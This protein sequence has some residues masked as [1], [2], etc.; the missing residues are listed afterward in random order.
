[1]TKDPPVTALSSS[2]NAPHWL[3]EL[4]L[5]VRAVDPH[6]AT[7]TQALLD[8]K[9]KP[10]GS[11]GRLERLACR[12]GTITRTPC[13][14]RRTKAIVVMGADHGVA[15]EGVSAYPPEVTAQMLA[16]F[17]QGGAAINVLARQANA[18]VVVVDMGARV[19][20]K[21][22]AVLDRRI[23]AGTRS[24]SHGPAMQVTEALQAIQVGAALVETLCH[25][26]IDLVGL[27]E[28]GIGN[29]T[30]AAAL[31]AAL[32]GLP[33]A[34]VTGRGT[35]IDDAMWARKVNVI[36]SALQTNREALVDP[37]HTLA[38][39]G[40][41]EIAGLVGVCLGAAAAGVPVVLDG[42]ITT[43]AALVAV[44]LCPWAEGY[45]LASHLS[46]ERGH[47]ALLEALRLEPLFDLELRLGEGTG[48][49]LA[50]PFIDAALAILHDMATFESAG[51]SGPA[52]DI[53]EP[54]TAPLGAPGGSAKVPPTSS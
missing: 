52:Q 26:G 21:S 2:A 46:V 28:M 1:M 24:A 35:G 43:A 41:F 44:R 17:A 22:P 23:A 39:L 51:V 27:G 3:V 5:A 53:T 15:D 49:A 38:A 54:D 20:V 36:E 34:Q 37:L 30:S 25:E 29:T 11:L 48:A 13:P 10:P 7:R 14:P 32:L 40:G 18:R 6:V 50:F 4:T 9:T 16:N 47:R 12:L 8:G 19:P 45:L 33:P 42:F 31:T